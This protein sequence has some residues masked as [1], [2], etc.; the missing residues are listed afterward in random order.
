MAL[1]CLLT[2]FL[3]VVSLAA[4]PSDGAELRLPAP[5][6]VRALDAGTLALDYDPLATYAQMDEAHRSADLVRVDGLELPGHER[7]DLL[8]RPVTVM[9][10][11]ATAVVNHA[12]GTQELVEP[13]VRLFSGHVPGRASNAFL[14]LSREQLNGYLE[15]DGSL[16]VLSSGGDRGDGHALLAEGSTLGA[17][18]TNWCHVDLPHVASTEPESGVEALALPQLRHAPVFMELDDRYRALFA[19]DQAAIDYCVT[20]VGAA[21]EI[22]RRDLGIVLEIPSGYINVWHTTP[23]WGVTDDFGDIG[24]VSAWW[25]TSA[26]PNRG[27][28]RAAVHVLTTP[29]FGGV[30]ATIAGTCS[31]GNGY[32]ISSVTGSFPQPTQHTSPGNWDLLVVAHEFGH[33]FGAQHT[34]D[35]GVQC[36]DGTGP[37]HGTIMGYCH[38]TFGVGG[39]G[40]RFHQESQEAIRLVIGGRACL[41]YQPILHGDYDGDGDR[42]ALDLAEFDAHQVQGFYSMAARETFDI[43]RDDLVDS[44]D[45]SLLVALIGGAAPAEAVLRMGSGVNEECLINW[46]APILGQVWSSTI[47][48]IRNNRPTFLLGYSGANPGLITPYGELLVSGVRLFRLTQPT[49]GFFADYHVPVPADPS[50]AG[51]EASV[52]GLVMDPSG[53][54]LCNAYDIRFGFF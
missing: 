50:L 41:D 1:P 16:F 12:D 19:S 42:D 46:Q 15:L 13:S 33:T 48:A 8:L 51:V 38:L 36:D 11:G 26:N 45:R 40:M 23:G 3:S 54:R 28:E 30:A 31:I 17:L 7:V 20:L 49:D 4:H 43:N 24:N 44:W 9:P 39:V 5:F 18:P 32:E 47:F 37:D 53:P 6:A 21:S 27:L 22:Y 52:Q 34:Q 35:V 10:R 14:A 29:V 25:R 2:G